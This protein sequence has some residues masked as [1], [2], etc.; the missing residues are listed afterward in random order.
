[1]T[2]VASKAPAGI[3]LVDDGELDGVARVLDSE[4]LPYARM[5]G[6]HIPAQVEPPRDLLIVTPRRVDR[7]RPAP[8]A[9]G[10]KRGRPLRI[11]AVQED[12]PSMRRR[13]RQA[14]LHLLVRQSADSEIWRLLIARALYRGNERR[15][16][17]RI[18]IGSRV[19]IEAGA[20]A[21]D[22]DSQTTLVDLSNRGCRLQTRET[23]SVGDPITF[24]LPTHE[25]SGGE[26][27]S[28]I[29]RGQVRRIAFDTS[30]GQTMLAIVFDPNMSEKNRAQLTALI[31]RWAAGSESSETAHQVIGPSIPACQLPS[32]PD[33]LLDDETDPPVAARSRICVELADVARGPGQER[34]SH[35]RARYASKLVADGRDGPVVLIGRDLSPGGM[36][37]ER[38]GLLGLGDRFRVA[39]HGPTLSEPIVV[40]AEITRDDGDAGFALVFDAVGAEV[41][42]ELEKLVA[43]LPD[44]ESLDAEE[45]EGLGA[46]L[47][48]ILLD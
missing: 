35:N 8:P 10:K 27:V 7:V 21:S 48:E 13:L 17:P 1:M 18:A 20:A 3:L 5:R 38:L 34:R 45:V 47:A 12:S 28:F 22:A 14:G 23:F 36:R 41:A 6:A 46:V 11:I 32:L 15:E 9:T 42:L 4:G 24:A 43:C 16:E 2:A 29:L 44:V 30:S 37:I 19:A 25:E 39:L 40:D 26:L 33:L 31:N